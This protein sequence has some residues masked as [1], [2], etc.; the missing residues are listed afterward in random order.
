[1]AVRVA[2]HHRTAYRYER[3]VELGPQTIRLRPAPHNRTPVH[4]FS[5]RVEPEQ[6][7]LNWQQDVHGNH[8]ARVVIPDKSDRVTV[9]VALVVDLEAYSPFDY[10]LEES[11]SEWPFDYEQDWFPD[12]DPYLETL[13]DTPVLDAF[14]DELDTSRRETNHF[15]VETNRAVQQ[16][17]KYEI[18]LEPGVQTPDET[19]RMGRGS[20][21]DSA[22][23][24]VQVLRRLGVAARF[25]S[26]YL[27][28][29]RPDVA[30]VDEPIKPEEDFTDLH[31]WCECF[32]PGAGWIGL[33][34]TS[35]LLAAEGHIPL[36]VAPSPSSAAPISG[37]VEECEAELDFEMSV[38]RV[39]DRARVTKPYTEGQWH[40]ILAVGDR[41]DDALRAQDVRLSVGGE[42]TF[43]SATEP[44]APEWNTE[45]QGGRKQDVG[46]RLALRLMERWFPGG[47]L[48]YGQGKWYPGEQLPR[49]A[50]SAYVRR[51]GVPLWTD[52]ELAAR[53]G[54]DHGH[55]PRDAERFALR[56]AEV[57]GLDDYVCFEAY[58]DVW[59]YLWREGRLPVN[60]D[61]LDA[62]L[63]D[64]LERER[65][66]RVFEQGLDRVV[67]SV[68]PLEHRGGRWWSGD[69]FLRRGHCFLMP[70]DSQMG[71]R[72]PLDSVPWA[73]PEHIGVRFPADPFAEAA[74][75]PTDFG[76]RRPRAGAA[77]RRFQAHGTELARSQLALQGPDAARSVVRSALCVEPR[78]GQLKVF[79]PPLHTLEAFVELVA[80]IER[81]AGEL[82]LPVQLEGYP[83][84]PDPR[85]ATFKVTPDPGVIE[86]NV[87]PVTSWRE[88][89]AQADDLYD[90]ARREELTAEKFEIDGAHIGS[91][92][93]NH[94]VMGAI[95][96]ED[97]PFLRRPDVLGSLLRYWHNHPSL[98]FLFSG[99]F[100]GPT[101]QAPRVDE[102]RDDS[103]YELELALSQLPKAGEAVVPWR[104][105]RILRNI[106]IDV[107]GNTHRTE[108]CIDKL[109]SPDGPHGRLGLL[110]LRAFEMPPHHRMSSV[111]QLLV[112]ALLAHF[113]KAP[114]ERTLVKWRT[115]L[116]DQFMLPHWVD[117]DFRRV[118]EDLDLAGYTLPREWFD[119]HFEFRFP[120]LGEI[121][122]DT[123][124]LELRGG[125]E[126]WHVL[127]EEATSTGQARYVDSS[128]ERLQVK[129]SG[130]V[131]ERYQVLCNSYALPMQPTATNGEFVA[132]VRY[133]AWQPPH[134]LH[135]EI[136]VHS[137]LRIDLYD[138]WNQRSIA[139]CTYHVVH[140]GGRASED[141]PVNAAA[142]ESRRLARFQRLGHSQGRFDPIA[143]TPNPR[144]PHQLDLRWTSTESVR[145]SS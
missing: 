19:L 13:A 20:C 104:V 122:L 39:V 7:F 81:T 11:A 131:E 47:V 140:P 111:Q 38:T 66:A 58:E 95:R 145:T 22:W 114:Y 105:D 55:G 71:Y 42:P 120:Y 78:G 85:L 3:P 32:V 15:L 113:W 12:I 8:L 143:V 141:R 88:A 97:S 17:V 102:A 5:L 100:I 127:G 82:S 103:T 84:P 98:S 25:A 129:V 49:W 65:L 57:L 37:V 112:R 116:H 91:G 23:L 89:V 67:G 132:G 99:R 43:V 74:P 16:A 54:H 45:A 108:F 64:P 34:P 94:V 87:P 142:A 4:R 139:G 56:L 9:E 135:P 117:T 59:Y 137:P 61:P 93:G 138:R 33:D 101:S 63:E 21:R 72:L 107:T 1:M 109:Y 70:G 30:P 124:R 125:L 51:D 115:A 79:L 44:D 48:H 46:D 36:A 121:A 106:L 136:G 144:F 86:V 128:V 92:G 118:L 62:R 60:V 35:G 133:R 126:P 53:T 80:A 83:A 18:R 24:L 41:V 31:A 28:Q 77:V 96:A 130:M 76:P 110:E 73:D 52:P 50:I 40:S 6:H 69:W 10:F 26:G 75:L 2:L 68:L 134:C 123:M 90:A 27:I 119:P 29:L 14:L